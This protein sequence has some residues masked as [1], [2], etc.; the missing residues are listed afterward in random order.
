MRRWTLLVVLLLL[1][2]PGLAGATA[3]D[4][5]AGSTRGPD[6]YWPLDG[7]GGTEA[8]HYDVRVAYDFEDKVLSGRTKVRLKATAELRSFSLDLLLPVR[9]VSV[10]GRRARFSKPNRHELRVVPGRAIPEGELFT[11]VVRYRGRPAPISYAGERSWLADRH[12]VV[13]MNQPHMAPWWFPSNDHPSD[14]ARF[15]IRVNV[16][17][18]KQVVSNGRLVSRKVGPRR[19]TT[20]WRMSD[21][22]TTYLAFFAA[23]DFVVETGRSAAGHRYYNAVSKRLPA[24]ERS[25]A[26]RMLRR[27]AGITDWLQ[28]QFGEYPFDSTGGVVTSLPVGFA[29]ENQT[30]PTYGSWIYPGVIVHEVAHQWFGDSVSVERWRDIWINEGFAT[31]AEAL[32]AAS[33]GGPSVERWLRGM[34]GA[35]CT[36]P[37]AGF[38]RV[39]L[40]D[41]GASRIFHTAVYDR[42]AMVLA[43][44]RNRIGAVPMR[45]LLRTWA[46]DNHD[47]NAGVADF[48]ALAED[49]SGQDLDSFFAAWL[50]GG[51]PPEATD[52]NGLDRDC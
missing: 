52:A 11:V 13:T 49:V 19:Q 26:V 9:A 17:R 36:A 5:A 50:D 41:P 35:W 16:P 43:A 20:H 46:R 51:R 27:T 23:G 48:R 10:D 2:A 31:Y 28:R 18:G 32:Y 14:K 29:L 34:Y 1:L 12:E 30:R 40:T 6:G 37:D 47:G 3:A 7:N 21:P 42:G 39:D 45:Q 4:P 33:H 15:D 24:G 25:R 38:W 22:M 44:L 8:R